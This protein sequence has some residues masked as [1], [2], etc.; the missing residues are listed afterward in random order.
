MLMQASIDGQSRSLIYG[1]RGR[2]IYYGCTSPD[3]KYAIF[4]VPETDGG[5][6]AEMVVMRLA[7][8]PIIVP[9][10][11]APLKALYPGAKSGPVHH[12]GQAGFEPHWTYADIASK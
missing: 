9:D 11:Y 4:S 6:D 8:A 1:E 5:I 10:D 2:H 12:L 7:D 3:D